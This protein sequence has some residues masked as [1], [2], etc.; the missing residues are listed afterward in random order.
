MKQVEPPQQT[1]QE[2][3]ELESLKRASHTHSEEVRR[4]HKL[5]AE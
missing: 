5:V 4:L 1:I 2:E 3:E